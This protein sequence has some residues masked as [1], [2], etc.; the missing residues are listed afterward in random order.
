MLKFR[1]F[2][3][4]VGGGGVRKVMRGHYLFNLFPESEIK[5]FWVH[6]TLDFCWLQ[7]TPYCR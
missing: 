1:A 6:E 2:R 3:E 4:G 7:N 5:Q